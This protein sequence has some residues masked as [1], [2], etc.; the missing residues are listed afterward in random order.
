MH[1][2]IRATDRLRG[3]KAFDLGPVLSSLA[4][5]VRDSS[6]DLSRLRVVCDWVQYRQSFRSIVDVREI[7]PSA[8]QPSDHGAYEL[9]IDMRRAGNADLDAELA[10]AMD[11]ARRGHKGEYLETWKPESESIIWDFNGLYWNALG[12][13]EQA[14]GRE[15]EQ[16]LPGGESDARNAD[17]ARES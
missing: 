4:R 13:W 17:A 9:A 14:T 5:A 12:L 16:A 3:D 10:K 1:I 7:L 2:D 15:Y 6:L 11:E 8:L